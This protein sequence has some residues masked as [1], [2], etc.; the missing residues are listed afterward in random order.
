MAAVDGDA[1][2]SLH[3]G[4]VLPAGSTLVLVGELDPAQATD[5]VARAMEGWSATGAAV[6]APPVW[7]SSPGTRASCWSTGPVWSKSNLRLGGPRR[8]APTR[9]WPPHGWPT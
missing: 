3:A 8:S 9:T 2:W 7:R 5:T 6:E 4:R 1:L